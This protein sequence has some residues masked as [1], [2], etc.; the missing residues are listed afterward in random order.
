MPDPLVAGRAETPVLRVYDV[1]PGVAG[2]VLVRDRTR[3]VGRA[4]VDDQ[5][6]E[7]A[8]RLAEQAGQALGRKPATLYTGIT[9]LTTERRRSN[10][11]GA[12]Y[13]RSTLT[14]VE[15]TRKILF[16]AGAGR[17]GT[18]LAGLMSRLGLHVPVPEV[19]ADETNPKGFGEPQWAVDFH[20]R[21]LEQAQVAVSDSRPDAWAR[22]GERCA[23]E[24]TLAE[25]ATWLAPHFAEADELVVKDPRLSWFLPL[26]REAA[27]RSEATPVFATMLRPPPE[28]VGSKQKYY[29]NRLG[30]AHL[31]ASWLN[32]LL[33]TE[34]DTRDAPRAFVRYADLL[35]DHRTVVESVGKQLDLAGVRA[36]TDDDWE[37]LEGF[38]DPS[39]RRIGL[40]WADLA[41]PPRLEELTRTAWDQLNSLTTDDTAEIRKT[42][43]EVRAGYAVLYA[44]SEAISKSSV[45]AAQ[46]ELGRRTD[47]RW[48]TPSGEPPRPSAEPSAEPIGVRLTGNPADRVPHRLRARVPAPVR[49]RSAGSSSAADLRVRGRLDVGQAMLGDDPTPGC[50]G[51][52]VDGHRRHE[53]PSTVWDHGSRRRGQ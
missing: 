39:L 18:R 11:M 42:L 37:R 22:T 53:V 44:E 52:R 45:V 14:P 6:L 4:V 30:S 26:W 31:T 25:A 41:L 38:I 2:G 7:L 24:E 47:G 33:H 17:S 10:L 32:M 15:R 16:I 8:M 20:N 43:D 9:T 35:G 46:M 50:R 34:L 1:Q 51:N 21:V 23:A 48:P 28:V 27:L 3:R 12:T 36:A 13:S 5:D 29:A 19:I 49:A 40:D